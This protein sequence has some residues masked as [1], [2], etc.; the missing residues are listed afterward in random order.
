MAKAPDKISIYCR[1]GVNKDG[2][3]GVVL[4][5]P[6]NSFK[7]AVLNPDGTFK[8]WLGVSCWND[9]SPRRNASLY[10]YPVAGCSPYARRQK[11]NKI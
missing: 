1:E 6:N 10:V 4:N 3:I 11:K 2:E 9:E 5:M 7:A 8:E